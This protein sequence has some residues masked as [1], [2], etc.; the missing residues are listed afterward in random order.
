LRIGTV[1]FVAARLTAAR[2]ARGLTQAEAAELTG[3]KPQSL[4]HYEQGRQSPSPEALQVLAGKLM[5]PERHFLRAMPAAGPNTP[6]VQCVRTGGKVQTA[7]S[8]RRLGWLRELAAYLR[9][10]V[11][12][13][14][15]RLPEAAERPVADVESAAAAAR[16]FLLP[17]VGL[18]PAPD[19]TTLLENHG[20]VTV[21]P[22]VDEETS[23]SYFRLL[24][25]VPYVAL[26][27]RHR[28]P[29]R[30]QVFGAHVLGHLVLHGKITA[31]EWADAATHEA[32]EA[33]AEH[34]ARAFLLPAA[35]FGKEVWSPAPDA[36]LILKRSWNCPVATMVRRCEDLGILDPEQSRRA[37]A[38]L[39]RRGWKTD[40][41][42]EQEQFGE[43]PRILAQSIRLI[44]DSGVRTVH[45]LLAELALDSHDVE[46][47]TGLPAGCMR[48]RE[49]LENWA[50][51]LRHRPV[52]A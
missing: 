30:T 38:G 51:R 32:L 42:G 41:P 47:L 18:G 24:D 43:S 19:M 7:R 13:P 50:P 31:A 3:I 46:D 5:L 37:L 14:P 29:S 49:P 6:L 9:E 27:R 15:V 34:F 4:C 28:R 52:Q 36:L 17:G 23:G 25:G 1:G 40:E 45:S 16:R 11:D 20:C 35:S 48:E 22:A 26:P 10:F 21:S 44:L 12:L 33:E 2:E 8:V 39:V